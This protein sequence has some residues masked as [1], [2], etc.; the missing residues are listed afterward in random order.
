MSP[1]DAMPAADMLLTNPIEDN[2]GNLLFQSSIFRTFI[3]K[4]IQVDPDFYNLDSSE[5]R[6]KEINDKY[7]YYLLPLANY[8]RE[9]YIPYLRKLTNLIKQ[10]TIPVVVIGVGLQAPTNYKIED[11]FSFDDD[12]KDFVKAV[13]ARSTIIGLRG[14]VTAQYLTHLGFQREKDFTVIGCPSMYTFG[15]NLHIEKKDIDISSIVSVNSARKRIDSITANYLE[16][17]TRSFTNHFFIPQDID[18]LKL[19]FTGHGEVKYKSRYSEYMTDAI[20]KSPNVRFPLNTPTWL[21]FLQNVDLVFGARIHGNIAGVLAG[22]PSVLFPIDTRTL[23]LAKYH[24]LNYIH[25]DKKNKDIPLIELIGDIDFEKPLKKQRKNFSHYIDFLNKNNLNHIYKKDINRKDAPY[26]TLI[27]SISYPEM[28]T[29]AATC[30][31]AERLLRMDSY[32]PR[33]DKLLQEELKETRKKA[34]RYAEKLHTTSSSLRVAKKDIARRDIMLNRK[35]VRLA[36]KIA[37]VLKGDFLK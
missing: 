35:S 30:S 17:N 16:Q 13:L 2:I 6:A 4:G 18:E 34:T 25:I 1:L 32:Y 19:I 11:G 7:D 15:N 37:G 9:S 5:R 3:D 12:V 23:E 31:T 26:D 10:L 28:I 14:E 33:L 29:S 8:F 20:Y 24:G 27:T 22:T 21:S 36:L